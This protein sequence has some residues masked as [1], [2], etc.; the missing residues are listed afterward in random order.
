MSGFALF[1]IMVK[2]IYMI[3]PPGLPPVA[4]FHKLP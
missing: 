2:M 4:A 1:V 3:I